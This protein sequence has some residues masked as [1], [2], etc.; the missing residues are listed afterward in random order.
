M[1]MDIGFQAEIF[2]NYTK[3][4][5]D[6]MRLYMAVTADKYELP[7][8]VSDK[9]KDIARYS[10]TSERNI[11]QGISHNFLGRKTKIKFVRIDVND[12]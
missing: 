11:Y 3:E 5:N 10:G 12:R 6:N 4:R 1:L 7:L 9:V 8:I 2:V